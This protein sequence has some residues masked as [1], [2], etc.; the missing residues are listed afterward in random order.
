MSIDLNL[1]Y[2]SVSIS[3][4]DADGKDYHGYV[5]INFNYSTELEKF[6]MESVEFDLLLQIKDFFSQ[7]T[8][9]YGTKDISLEDVSILINLQRESDKRYAPDLVGIVRSFEKSFDEKMGL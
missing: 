3:T 8:S 6:F 1:K 2:A 4:D 9:G 5:A 7:K